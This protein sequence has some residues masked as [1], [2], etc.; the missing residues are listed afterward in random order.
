MGC[1]M[2]NANGRCRQ[3][4]RRIAL[5]TSPT[6]AAV[7]DMIQV[8]I[9]RWP[10]AHIVVVPV[11]VQG[12]DA[13]GRIAGA[14]ESVC[15]IESVDV[16]ITGR[17]GGSLEDLWAF[18]EEA[19]ARAIAAC[20]VP[21][22]TAVGHET[23]VSIADLVADR[24]ALTP[25]EAAELVVPSRAD[26]KQQVRQLAQRLDRIVSERI[27]HYRLQLA[28][29]RARSVIRQP[30]TLIH[31]RRQQVDELAEH[32]HRSIELQVERVRRNLAATAA[33][34]DAL[35]PLKVL[36]RGYSLTTD[37]KGNLITSSSELLEGQLLNTRVASG[38][39]VSAVQSIKK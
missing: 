38:T 20:P 22:V 34:L 18:N 24:R 7:R 17:G 15:Q 29:I 37:V 23:D 5:V 26:L 16:V 11:P 19:V 14:L 4:P 28:A 8:I 39:I 2:K 33:S 36:A 31:D 9:R 21:V 1:S 25:S 6:G 30:M 13:A 32:A 3:F 27:Q 35:N 12:P 10:A